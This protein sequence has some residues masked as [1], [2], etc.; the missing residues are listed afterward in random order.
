VGFGFALRIVREPL[1]Q[2]QGHFRGR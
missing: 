2:W 1:A